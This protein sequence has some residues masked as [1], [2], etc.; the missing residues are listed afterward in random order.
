MLHAIALADQEINVFNLGCDEYCEVND[1]VKWITQRLAP[2][3]S[4]NTAAAT[5][6]GSA[7]IRSFSSTARKILRAWAGSRG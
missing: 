4:S 1:L 3:S 2:A 6:D 7:T 5:A